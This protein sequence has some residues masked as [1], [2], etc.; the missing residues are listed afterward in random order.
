M[1]EIYLGGGGGWGVRE[2]RGERKKDETEKERKTSKV[3]LSFL[4]FPICSP[5]EHPHRLRVGIGLDPPPVG[6]GGV[7]GSCL[8]DLR[9]VDPFLEQR[10]LLRGR[11]ARGR[12]RRGHLLLW[13]R[14]WCFFCE[15]F[16]NQRK[17]QQKNKTEEKKH[18]ENKGKKQEEKQGGGAGGEEKK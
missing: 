3:S 9:Q 6:R 11:R 16:F 1:K 14:F 17:Q 10:A 15:G 13:E 7:V 8:V 12:V 5:V 2:R 18:E 4:S